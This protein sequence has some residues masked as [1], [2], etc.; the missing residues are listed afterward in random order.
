MPNLNLKIFRWST[1]LKLVLEFQIKLGDPRPL[2]ISIL[3]PIFK[4]TKILA[5]ENAHRAWHFKGCF[6]LGPLM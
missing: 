2:S 6:I 5:S 1:A 3:W 4:I